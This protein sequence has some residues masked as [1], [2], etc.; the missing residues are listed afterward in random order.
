MGKWSIIHHT[1]GVSKTYSIINITDGPGTTP[2]SNLLVQ[3]RNQ[4]T[5]KPS[6][7][8]P[9]LPK[10]IGRRK[11]HQFINN[12][13]MLH[14]CNKSAYHWR[15]EDPLINTSRKRYKYHIQTTIR[16][17]PTA[18]KRKQVY[19]QVSQDL[20]RYGIMIQ[21]LWYLGIKALLTLSV[22]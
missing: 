20:K 10:S 21:K 13:N 9:S 12:G 22:I 2:S 14:N 7:Q 4:W 1:L 8:S 17:P 11:G 16:A 6:H 18:R 15:D 3:K 19:I 5:K